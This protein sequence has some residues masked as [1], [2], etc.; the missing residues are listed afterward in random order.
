MTLNPIFGKLF[1]ELVSNGYIGNE[2]FSS[3]FSFD[4]STTY[5]RTN[6]NNIVAF[7][8]STNSFSV[9]FYFP[10]SVSDIEN[11]RF[12]ISPS[13][14]VEVKSNTYLNIDREDV[15]VDGVSVWYL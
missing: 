2:P 11:G 13:V 4:G 7:H 1:S 10:K 9:T 6:R 15:Y 12:A 3:R 8:E 14:N 5:Y